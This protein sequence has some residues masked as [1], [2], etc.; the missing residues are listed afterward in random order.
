[1]PFTRAI[2]LRRSPPPRR[3]PGPDA[4]TYLHPHEAGA[5]LSLKGTSHIRDRVVRH[6]TLWLGR[7]PRLLPQQF[8]M[9][10]RLMYIS[11]PDCLA[12][13][14]ARTSA[15]ARLPQDRSMLCA[16]AS[17]ARTDKQG[18][19]DLARTL[20]I[21]LE[22]ELR[23]DARGRGCHRV[24][25]SSSTV[26]D[27]KKARPLP[28]IGARTLDKL[29]KQWHYDKGYIRRHAK[30]LG[31]AL[32]CYRAKDA[33]GRWSDLTHVLDSDQPRLRAA[34]GHLPPVGGTTSPMVDPPGQQAEPRRGPAPSQA[35]FQV[36]KACY[37]G[38]ASG[39]TLKVVLR[40][41]RERFPPP[42]HRPPRRVQD[43]S[44]YAK[45]YAIRAGKPWPI[46]R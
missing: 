7:A 43:V 19:R 38:M 26:S 5:V 28:P 24:V 44:I 6:I 10:K 25:V 41:V 13:L 18:F 8:P 3:V 45:R 11:E 16:A 31:V 27:L 20:D 36:Y 42:K 15:T 34:L 21:A 33:L 4:A 14:A 39:K 2:L 29:A 12:A 23:L 37:D 40:E 46:P 9:R 1:M 35:T 17:A 22:T 30:A 32:D